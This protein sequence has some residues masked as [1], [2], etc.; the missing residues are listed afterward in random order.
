[1]SYLSDKFDLINRFHEE[2]NGEKVKLFFIS[3]NS[4]TERHFGLFVTTEDRVYGIGDNRFGQLG[5][6]HNQDVDDFT[7]ITKLNGLGICEF[8]EGHCC[9]FART[10]SLGV[11]S[12]GGNNWSQLGRGYSS[13]IEEYLEP[14][15]INFF[16]N[17]QITQISCGDY[18]NIGLSSEG[19]VY[20]WGLNH[21]GQ[22]GNETYG[23]KVPSPVP[24]KVSPKYRMAQSD[25]GRNI[26]R[27]QGNFGPSFS[28][29]TK[30]ETMQS[31]STESLIPSKLLI[32]FRH[33]ISPL[34]G[35]LS[36]SNYQ[37]RKSVP[38]MASEY[39]VNQNDDL[40]KFESIKAFSN[41]S[42]AITK[43]N[44]VYFWGQD[45][46]GLLANDEKKTNQAHLLE[47]FKTNRIECNNEELFYYQNER[48]IQWKD[49]TQ[50]ILDLNKVNELA[51]V[52]N[53]TLICKSDGQVF[54]FID[55]SFEKTKCKNFF[56][57]FLNESQITFKTIEIKSDFDY[58]KLRPQINQKKIL[59]KIPIE[60]DMNFKLID[61][62]NIRQL[63]SYFVIKIR[64]FWV[65]NNC[66]CIESDFSD[67]TLEDTIKTKAKAFNRP[68]DQNMNSIEFFISCQMFRELTEGLI[69]LHSRQPPIVHREL[70][71]TT[72]FLSD[73]KSRKFLKMGDIG[74]G[75]I[76]EDPNSKISYYYSSDSGYESYQSQTRSNKEQAQR[77]QLYLAPE[78]IRGN[79]YTTKADIYS[80]AMIAMDL[81][82]LDSYENW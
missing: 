38:T 2:L 8:I 70:R 48:V 75:Q 23:G 39:P 11:Y 25:F 74:L 43:D 26:D 55:G 10:V 36:G 47:I 62:K 51:M 56:E 78:V 76:C 57:Y 22:I 77:R 7:E 50:N 66:L 80:L 27:L 72:I 37:G 53:E 60:K 1:M 16:R 58:Q 5:F 41:S 54:E 31:L 18:H 81:F 29:V 35:S 4:Y 34:S 52:D 19:Q 69:Y 32:D 9:M 67:Q 15:A 65:E 30:S 42:F 33:S 64:E 14:E 44:L 12:W 3:K 49:N 13:R 45:L 24:L 6:G 68:K 28:S 61:L 71:P 21:H 63:N 73:G 20:T 59:T 40:V 17:K 46:W 79:F 82:E